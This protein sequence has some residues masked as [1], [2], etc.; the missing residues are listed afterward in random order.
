MQSLYTKYWI[1]RRRMVHTK[2][3]VGQEPRQ[4]ITTG[5]T[6]EKLHTVN[7]QKKNINYLWNKWQQVWQEHHLHKTT[8]MSFAQ[9]CSISMKSTAWS[10]WEAC[11]AP[12]SHGQLLPYKRT[13]GHCN[14]WFPCNEKMTESRWSVCICIILQRNGNL[15][16]QRTYLSFY[17][18]LTIL[19]FQLSLRKL[20]LLTILVASAHFWPQEK[21]PGPSVAQTWSNFIPF[22]AHAAHSPRQIYTF[23]CC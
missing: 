5:Q 21:I 14:L 15:E 10:S 2:I 1:L 11:M 20:S 9:N 7:S 6:S 4:N 8:E 22:E 3:Y 19:P 13:R 17:S 12:G 23:W 16:E 18:S